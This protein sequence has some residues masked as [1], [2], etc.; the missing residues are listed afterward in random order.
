MAIARGLL[1]IGFLMLVGSPAAAQ[2][3][4]K[5]HIIFDTSGSMLSSNADGSEL[6][7]NVGQ[8]SRIYQLKAALFDVLQGMGA[9]EVDFALST[10]PMMVDPTRKPECCNTCIDSTTSYTCSGHYYV[11]AGQNSEISGWSSRHGCKVSTHTPATQTNAS[12][13]ATSNPCSAWYTQYKNEVLKVPF[14]STTPEKVM[15]YF[16]QK[17]DTDQLAPLANPEV[18]AAGQWYTPLGK[19]LFYAHGYFHKEVVL[20][21]TDYRKPCERLTIA[22]FTDGDETCN[23]SSSDAFYATKWAA[24][25]YNNMG[26]VTHTVAIDTS[27]GLLS[28]IASSGHGNYYN[29][30]GN[31]TALKAAFLDIIAKSLPPS[32]TCNGK[33]DDCDQL[34]DEDFPLKGT[35]CHNGKLGVCYKTGVYVCNSA[36]SGVVCNA[37]NATGTAEKCNGLDDDCDGQ[38][39][40][41]LTN[42]QPVP[43]QPEICNGKD[44]DCDSLVD[45]GIPSIPCG[46]DIGECKPGTTKCTGGKMVCAGGTG[47]TAEQCNGLDDDCDGA[48]DGMSEQCYSFTTGCVPKASGSGY[49]CTGF[50]QPGVRICT[51]TQVA[52]SWTGVWGSCQGDV[53]PGKEVCNGLDDDCD[54][55]I[56]EDAECPGGSQCVNGACTNP[57][58]SGEFGCPTG[59]YCKDGWCIPDPCNPKTC[60]S[61]QICK[62]G[63]CIDPCINVTCGK[64]ETCVKGACV[65]QS[66]YNPQNKCAAGKT[67]VQGVCQADPCYQV[68]CNANEYCLDGSCVRSCDTIQCG[69]GEVCEVVKGSDG[70]PQAQCV[71]DDCAKQ[72][73]GS[74]YVCLGGACV[75]DPC[76]TVKC[77]TGQVCDPA[78]GA[79]VADPCEKVTCPASF[80]CEEGMCVTTA[81]S[82]TKELLGTGGGGVACSLAADGW[83]GGQPPLLWLLLALVALVTRRRRG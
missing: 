78:T 34:V 55:T 51:A 35:A 10:F 30:S 63:L 19:S 29:V 37:A 82:S 7:S 62:A 79:C 76:N 41:G 24:N 58:S 68:S 38:I 5:I 17:E 11:V 14:A 25:L 16:D 72:T 39:D 18:R 65:D 4:P 64:Y 74:G 70:K 69:A 57:C 59:Q 26:V 73:C 15:Y 50:C 33:D 49:D 67:C 71:K 53:G 80:R 52:G 61:G 20:P 31:T 45:E 13:G 8:T 75:V 9:D 32:E 54:G 40:E 47:P 3:K 23:T 44:D 56:D 1:A 48:R 60:P 36:G 12:C 43:C 42:C 22:F 21:A 6:C 2:I 77:E 83:S 66:C 46:K 28:Q 81:V 27:A